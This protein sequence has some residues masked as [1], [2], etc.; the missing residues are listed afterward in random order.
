MTDLANFGDS[1]HWGQGHLEQDKFPGTVA[2]ALGFRLRMAAH[3]GA[4]IGV[5][6]ACSGSTNGEVPYSCPSI[7]DQVRQYGSD[8]RDTDVVLLNGG[9]NDVT[10]QRIINPLVKPDEIAW[11]TRKHCQVHMAQLLQAVLEK[12]DQS[13]TRIIVTSYF[14]IFS[15][16]SDLERIAHY[17]RVNLFEV[18]QGPERRLERLAV[19]K[20]VVENAQRFWKES[21]RA[22]RAAVSDVGSSRIWFADVPFNDDNAMFAPDPWLFNVHLEGLELVPEDPVAEQRRGACDRFHDLP[23]ERAACYVASAGHP[24]L[25]GSRAYADTILNLLH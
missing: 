10:V 7:L 23:W 15:P 25:S 13:R 8:T 17:L 9:I 3:S 2:R 1:V 12:F 24:N 6:V 18:P 5:D 16:A 14:P 21:T 20:R 4:I 11:L 22:L 19:M